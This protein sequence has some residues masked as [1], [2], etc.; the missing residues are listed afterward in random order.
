MQGQSGFYL[1]VF[2]GQGSYV[3]F[4]GKIFHLFK[5]DLDILQLDLDVQTFKLDFVFASSSL[6]FDLWMD[7][8][9]MK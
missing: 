6:D 2:F 5:S 3:S 4:R 1:S 9:S 7:R 8:I